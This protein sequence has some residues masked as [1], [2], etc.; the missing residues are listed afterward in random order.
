MN[1][2]LLWS[3]EAQKRGAAPISFFNEIDDE[4]IP[5]MD[6]NFSYLEANYQL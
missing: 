5:P 2:Q 6:P 1:L 4:A 3:G